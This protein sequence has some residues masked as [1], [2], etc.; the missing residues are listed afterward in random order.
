MV[1]TYQLPDVKGWA[2]EVWLVADDD[3]RQ[4]D[5][6]RVYLMTLL[7]YLRQSLVDKE[8]DVFLCGFEWVFPVHGE[9]EDNA[10][11]LHQVVLFDVSHRKG[12]FL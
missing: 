4:L 11:K 1:F 8:C 9:D 6:V 12:I 5:R 3:A 2:Y 7:L 10:I